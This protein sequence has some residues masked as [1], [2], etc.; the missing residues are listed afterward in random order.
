M[1]CGRKKQKVSLLILSQALKQI[2]T[3]LFSHVRP[4]ASVSFIHDDE[5]W[6]STGEA[7][8]TL[9]RL[10]V[11]ETDDCISMDIEEVLRSGEASFEARCR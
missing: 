10:D 9:L 3:L 5:L 4:D 6:A 8:S 2:E 7:V 1:R 11:V